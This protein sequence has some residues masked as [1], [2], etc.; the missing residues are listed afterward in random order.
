MAFSLSVKRQAHDRANGHCEGCGFP[1]GLSNPGE[2]DHIKAKWKGG[3]D[4]LD[5][6]QVLG[7]KCC[8]NPKSADDKK[9]SAR[10]DRWKDRHRGIKPKK[11]K[12]PYMTAD[13]VIHRNGKQT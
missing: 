2:V 8:H 4:T 1:L 12:I 11:H 13:G 5:N 3:A 7:K 9:L 10:A 6:A